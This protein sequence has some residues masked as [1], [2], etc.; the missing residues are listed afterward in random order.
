MDVIIRHEAISYS[1]G[2]ICAVR[3]C[4]VPT[5]NVF[6][7]CERGPVTLSLSKG[8]RRGLRPRASTSSA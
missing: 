6:D 5:H 1:K 8:A 7:F 2:R 3:D 4:F